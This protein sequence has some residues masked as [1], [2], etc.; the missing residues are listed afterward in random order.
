MDYNGFS[1]YLVKGKPVCQ[2]FRKSKSTCTEYRW[3]VAG[4]IRV[5]TVFRIVVCKCIG[6]GVGLISGTA[7]T[8]VDMNCKYGILASIFH[9]RQPAY[10]NGNK[11]AFTKTVKSC[12]ADNF[13]IGVASLYFCICQGAVVCAEVVVVNHINPPIRLTAAVQKDIKYFVGIF[14]REISVPR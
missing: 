4:V 10:H 14:G 12:C 11:H 9:L 2:K 13:G 6:K 7:C 5:R 3:H 1:D 8:A